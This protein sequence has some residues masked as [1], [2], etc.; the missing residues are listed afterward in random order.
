MKI[1]TV[2]YQAMMSPRWTERLPISTIAKTEFYLPTTVKK[3]KFDITS[4]LVTWS[5]NWFITYIRREFLGAGYCIKIIER[6][7]ILSPKQVMLFIVIGDPGLGEPLTR[8]GEQFYQIFKMEKF[9][10]SFGQDLI[11]CLNNDE[12]ENIL[13]LCYELEIDW[14]LQK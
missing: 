7:L 9:S 13:F 3:K 14:Y 6:F 2:K 8:S 11:L 1:D 10:L 12:V 4:S 5:I